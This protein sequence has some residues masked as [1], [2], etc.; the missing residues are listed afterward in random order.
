[1]EEEQEQDTHGNDFQ[2]DQAVNAFTGLLRNHKNLSAE[3][4]SEWWG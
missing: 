2:Q 4:L 3:K 1:M